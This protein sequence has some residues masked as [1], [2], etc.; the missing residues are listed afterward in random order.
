MKPVE[1]LADV[2]F[3]HAQATPDREAF[4]FLIDR[5]T[6]QESLSFA[7]LYAE[8]QGLADELRERIAP[9]A[10]V[11]LVFAPGLSFITA[12]LG[13]WL[14]RVAAVPLAPETFRHSPRER[15]NLLQRLAAPCVLCDESTAT[16]HRDDYPIPW[17][18]VSSR[19]RAAP[20][21][22]RP[23][24]VLDANDVALLQFTSGSTAAPRGVV[25]AHGN[26]MANMAMIREAFGH[27]QDST[28]V[29]WAPLYHDQ[30]LIGNVLQPLYLG[31]RCVLFSPKTF[32]RDP[33]LWLQT[34]SDHRVHTSGG[35]NFAYDLCVARFNSAR[36]Q[37]VDL[38]T[39]Q[40]AFNGAEPV[41]ADTLTRFGEC[42]APYGFDQR[43]MFPCYGLA[44]ATLFASGGP[45]RRMP[46]VKQVAAAPARIGCGRAPTGAGLRIV[47]PHSGAPCRPYEVGEIRIAGSHV[48]HGYWRDDAATAMHFGDYLRTGDLGFVDDDGELFPTGRIK[49]LVIQ[50][51]RN[52]LPDDIERT[53]AV[54]REELDPHRGVVFSVDIGGRETVIAV[55]EVKRTARHA[56]A[57]TDIVRAIRKQVAAEHGLTLHHVILVP[58]GTI[59]LTTSGKKRR[60]QVRADYLAGTLEA[61]STDDAL[62]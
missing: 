10:L 17:L 12:L 9:G 31:S 37:G 59:P 20:R 58:H 41:Q 11:P 22:M 14:L 43:S 42:F 16:L 24:P 44:E 40:I 47:D 5:H 57:V 49:E 60:A 8:A 62:A 6:E 56:P 32:V 25:I 53:I 36:L 52:Y 13:C 28:V 55:H 38:S 39:W 45:R 61:M 3:R 34:I 26:V 51:G 18:C 35:P 7:Q 19:R 4:R 21:V 15:H 30:G 46:V 27:D 23:P 54:A 33:L 48:A 1:S 2:V 50:H 29:G